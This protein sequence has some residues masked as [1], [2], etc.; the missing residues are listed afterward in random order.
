MYNT[1]RQH[2]SLVIE[3]RLF[4]LEESMYKVPPHENNVQ[5]AMSKRSQAT[6]PEL[7]VLRL[8]KQRIAKRVRNARVLLIVPWETKVTMLLLKTW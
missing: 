3:E 6:I 7:T 8:Q 1:V 4:H 2:N 5:E